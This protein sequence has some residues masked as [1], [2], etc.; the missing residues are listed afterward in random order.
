M[1]Q[2][3]EHIFQMGWFNHHLDSHLPIIFPRPFFFGVVQITHNWPW[4]IL[5]LFF[6]ATPATKNFIKERETT[7]SKLWQTPE[8]PTKHLLFSQL[9]PT[10]LYRWLTVY[11]LRIRP[12]KSRNRSSKSDSAG[13]LGQFKILRFQSHS[14]SDSWENSWWFGTWC[15]SCQVPFL[16]ALRSASSPQ[17]RWKTLNNFHSHPWFKIRTCINLYIY[18]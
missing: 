7:D 11:K 2:F 12:Q 13:S 16:G 9:K 3:D 17:K 15:T 18:I 6:D 5:S 4:P 8:R 1:I 10:F 14:Q